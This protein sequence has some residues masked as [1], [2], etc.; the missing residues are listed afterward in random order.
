LTERFY[1]GLRDGRMTVRD[2][3]GRA[4]KHPLEPRSVLFKRRTE[5][6]G[7]SRR[8]PIALTLLADA[9]GD[10][11]SAIE[12]YE[13]FSRRVVA[14]FPERWPDRCLHQYDRGREACCAL[15]VSPPN[16]TLQPDWSE[17]RCQA[18]RRKSLLCDYGRGRRSGR[19]SRGFL[20]SGDNRR[21]AFANGR[22]SLADW[23]S[24]RRR[25]RRRS[26]IG[27]E[28]LSRFRHS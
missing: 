24:N 18:Y 17:L 11:A 1:S 20:A 5:H 12:A 21:F 27:R 16:L 26:Y 10:E 6:R 4:E 13:Y 19:R 23:R 28:C 9:L 3:I 15:I 14:L 25:R 8:A 7:A 22:F 2:G